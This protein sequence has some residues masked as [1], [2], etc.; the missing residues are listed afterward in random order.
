[1]LLF[2][3]IYMIEPEEI[4]SQMGGMALLTNDELVDRLIE[5]GE[6]NSY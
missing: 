5:E 6:I 2:M 4:V 3:E 1:M